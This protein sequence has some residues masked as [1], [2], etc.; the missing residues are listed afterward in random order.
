M[1][2]ILGI[3]AVLFLAFLA[4]GAWETEK[5]KRADKAA[6]AVELEERP[7]REAAIEQQLASARTPADVLAL[8]EHRPPKSMRLQRSENALWVAPHCTYLKTEKDVEYRGRSS[9]V[10]VRVAKGLTVRTGGSRGRRVVNEQ[11]EAVET[12]TAVLTDRHIY[13]TGD[14][15]ERFRVKLSKLVSAETADD[16]FLFQRDNTTARPEAFLSD[17]ARVFE[18]LLHWLDENQAPAPEAPDEPEPETDG[19][20]D[21]VAAGDADR[22]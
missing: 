3:G 12:G 18:I 22:E 19:M 10:S 21:A 2:W 9:G 4:L 5:K 16:G 6:R 20:L 8:C 13:F 15:K 7:A 14:D 1:E 17:D 11:L